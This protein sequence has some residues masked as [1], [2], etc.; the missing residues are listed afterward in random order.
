MSGSDKGE[1]R[2]DFWDKKI[3]CEEENK[4]LDVKHIHRGLKWFF[5][6]FTLTWDIYSL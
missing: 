5:F 6:L 4:F 3:M 1:S 2:D